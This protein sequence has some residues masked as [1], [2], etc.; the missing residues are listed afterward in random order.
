[1]GSRWKVLVVDDD[2]SLRRAL[3]RTLRRAGYDV[4]AYRSADELAEAGACC[5]DAC[6]VLDVNLPGTSGI[7]FR[8][9]LED[10][11]QHPPTIFITALDRE[12]TTALASFAPIAVLHKP[13]R[14]E[15][16]L[17]AVDRVCRN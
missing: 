5:V 3:A 1:M 7:D 9:A 13:F 17:S 2:D 4:E 8:R 11:G 15:D 12:D 14:N 10:A 16:L 6:L